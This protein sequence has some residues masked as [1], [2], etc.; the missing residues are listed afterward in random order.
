MMFKTKEVSYGNCRRLSISNNCLIRIVPC[1]TDVNVLCLQSGIFT[2]KPYNPDV[3]SGKKWGTLGKDFTRRGL[4]ENAGPEVGC[5]EWIFDT[6][7]PVTN[8]VAVG[9]DGTVYAASEEGILFAIE[10]NGNLLWSYDAK[11]SLTN[12]PSIGN[13]GTI[14]IAGENGKLFAVNKFGNLRWT[15]QTGAA[16]SASPAVSRDGKIF[17]CSQDGKLYALGPDGSEL[18][19]FKTAGLGTNISGSIVASPVIDANGIVY[20]EGLYDPNLYAPRAE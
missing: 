12:S 15:F 17:T 11:T 20:I 9:Q 18:W 10:A 16:I 13:D 8:S 5:V 4:S 3:E 1:T 7:S 2:I 14:Y 6:N 19:I